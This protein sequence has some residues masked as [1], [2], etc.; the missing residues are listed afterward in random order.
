[1]GKRKAYLDQETAFTGKYSTHVLN[2]LFQAY[3]PILLPIIVFIVFG[4]IGRIAILSNANLVGFWVDSFC[5]EPAICRPLPRLLV[6]YNHH[7]FLRLLA[8]VTLGGFLSTALFRVGFSRLSAK[9][10]S[11]LY[12]EVTLR[13]SRLPIRF[14][15]TTPVGRIV[16]RFS[17]DYGNVFRLFGGPLA[18]F[19]VIVFDLISMMVLVSVASVWY[20]PI[21]VIIGFANYGIYRLNRDRLRVERRALSA[22]RSPSIA[23]FAETTQ[24]ASTIRIFAR[25][26]TFF[27]RFRR[28][29]DSFLNQKLKTTSVA[30]MFSTQ[31]NSLTAVLLLA[32]GVAGYVLSRQGLLTV[33]SIGVAFTFIVLSG[34]SMQMFFEWMAQFEEAMTGVERLD[35]YLRRPIEGGLKLPSRTEFQTNHPV[36]DKK[37]ELSLAHSR[38]VPGRSASVHVES[39]WFRYGADLPWVLK[40]LDFTVKSG[41]KIGIVGRTGSGKTS[42]VQALFH[43]YPFERGRI[44]IEKQ[45]PDIGYDP[46]VAGQHSL[47]IDPNHKNSLPDSYVDLGLFRRSMALISQEP[48]LFRGT[49]REN[50]DL[51]NEYSDEKL[52][53]AIF[54]VGLDEWLESQPL[55]FETMIEE[56]GR[57]L[58]AGEKQLLCMA[59]C[60]LQDAP[61]VVMD[62]AT[63]AIDPQSE[64]ILVRAT[65]EFFADRTQIIIAHRLSTLEHCD[66]VLWLQNGEIQM[67]D[68]PEIVLPIFSQTQLA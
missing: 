44:L 17:S 12:D 5:R 24:G 1:M 7:D 19:F 59:R 67:F 16:T 47:D 43:L 27:M 56:R 42:F 36:Q 30:L 34:S 49:L 50:L 52:N 68:R 18:E 29:N 35:E 63:S 11:R 13:T 31:M 10:V 37:I 55:K 65:R 15:D 4:F 45:E 41:E 14:F 20:F 53:D 64:E 23:H 3:R 21:F 46:S 22:S 39:L 26:E 60:L 8:A 48:T 58:S 62:E 32:T 6:N 51:A 2:T 54:R 9:A 40:G 33:G 61:I 25:Q 28:L 57:N 66:R 38:L